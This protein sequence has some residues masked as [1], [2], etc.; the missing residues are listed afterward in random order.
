M[1]YFLVKLELLGFYI[2]QS[3][4][5]ISPIIV[6]HDAS[7]TKPATDQVWELRL[8]SKDY[9]MLAVIKELNA[10]IPVYKCNVD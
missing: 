7:S 4:N 5:Q 9:L 8:Q 3:W 2:M 6:Q 10:E 1:A